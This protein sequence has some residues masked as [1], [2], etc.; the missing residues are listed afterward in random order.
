MPKSKAKTKRKVVKRRTS[1]VTT[2]DD[3]TADDALFRAGVALSVIRSR[4]ETVCSVAVS[5]E[6]LTV[7]ETHPIVA[8]Q[9]VSE[10]GIRECS[11]ALRMIHEAQ[12]ALKAMDRT[13]KRK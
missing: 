11:D 9:A 13:K 2:T 8:I 12:Q 7:A 4:F 5:L 3:T 6:E 10:K 1:P